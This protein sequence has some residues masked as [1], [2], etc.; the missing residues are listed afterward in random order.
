[1]YVN[2]FWMGILLTLVGGVIVVIILSLI[3]SHK[4][5]EEEED[6]MAMSEEEFRAMIAMAV[7]QAAVEV[8]SKIMYGGEDQSGKEE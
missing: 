5:T 6:G 1:M 7:N 4:K 8:L 2:P 3:A